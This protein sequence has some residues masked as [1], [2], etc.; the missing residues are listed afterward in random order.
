VSKFD[1][2]HSDRATS[3]FWASQSMVPGEPI[4]VLII[5]DSTDG[6]ASL[7]VTTVTLSWVREQ[8]S[9]LRNEPEG[10]ESL[11][12]KVCALL[13]GETELSEYGLAVREADG[14]DILHLTKLLT[15][16]HSISMWSCEL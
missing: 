8:V 4:F 13:P 12:V 1:I 16:T 11:A 10:L 3:V 6:K 15:P 7:C 14:K 9:Q 2:P 5:N